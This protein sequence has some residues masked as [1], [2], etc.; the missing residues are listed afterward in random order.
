MMRLRNRD[1][2]YISA[3]YIANI[4][5]E[6]L[7]HKHL[8]Y[9][10]KKEVTIAGY[11]LILPSMRS[12]IVKELQLFGIHEPMATK[13]Y[14]KLLQPGDVIIDVG[15]NLGYY[16]AVASKCIGSN[17]IIYGFE[18]DP[19]LYRCAQ[20]NAKLLP[21]IIFLLNVAVSDRSGSINFYRSF[22]PN[23]GSVLYS[24]ELKP[25][26][27]IRVNTISLDEF[28]KSRKIIPDVIRMDIE[29]GINGI[30]WS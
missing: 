29:G 22:I 7:K 13:F 6:K 2:D 5:L 18:P 17:G 28:C 30:I 10:H 23:Y 19:H 4:Q 1:I 8:Y 27:T 9:T 3:L 21:S 15:T 14:T 26:E 20:E 24:K 25:R 16:L 12:G 11:K